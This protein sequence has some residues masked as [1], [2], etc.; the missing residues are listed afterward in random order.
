MHSRGSQDKRPRFAAR[1]MREQAQQARPAAAPTPSGESPAKP[2]I[3]PSLPFAE[4][5]QG[6][7][8]LT[9]MMRS[10]RTSDGS[11]GAVEPMIILSSGGIEMRMTAAEP[12]I[13]RPHA[14]GTAEPA[15]P[16]WLARIEKSLESVAKDLRHLKETVQT[17]AESIESV[18][19]AVAQNEQMV[20]SIVES[21]SAGSGD[22]PGALG[23]LG[24]LG[25]LS[26]DDSADT[27]LSF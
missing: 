17:Q 5:L 13:G 23:T 6:L 20:E 14:G 12:V 4:A 7:L 11:K 16:D 25:E 19:A 9:E 8:T 10:M 26:L 21:L 22:N 3:T 24:E 18:R 1:K 2:L 15:P 27:P